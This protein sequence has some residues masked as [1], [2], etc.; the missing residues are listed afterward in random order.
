MTGLDKIIEQIL[1][2]AREEAKAAL[3]EAEENCT[4]LAAEHAERA[5]QLRAE[6]AEASRAEG[7][8]IVEKPRLRP[9]RCVTRQ[10]PRLRPRCLPWQ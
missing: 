2:G 1:A 9:S 3:H 7:E 10:W 4:R 5:E 8:Q 6:I